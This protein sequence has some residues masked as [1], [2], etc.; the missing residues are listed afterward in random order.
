[1]QKELALVYMVAGIS[2]RFLG[3][4]KQLAVVGAKGE[5]LIECSLNQALPAGFSKIVFIVGNRTEKPFKEKFGNSYKGIP[6]YYALQYYDE[7]ARDKPWGTTD[8]LC[9]AKSVLNCPFIVCNGDDLYGENTFRILTEHLNK[10]GDSAAVGFDLK[11]VLPEEGKVNRGIFREENEHIVDLKEIIGI[12]KS[13]IGIKYPVNSLCSM[14]IFALQPSV[15]DELGI[16]LE[17]FKK[18]NKGDRRKE[19]LLPE[20]IS[21][22][23]KQKKLS[24]RL[25]ATPDEW[26]G[27][28]NP[29]DDEI[30]KEKLARKY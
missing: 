16:I 28:T 29:G 27:V 24:M 17:K 23:I 1:M 4:I 11:S 25:Y 30:I 13:D 15:L 9:S 5:T 10:H 18:E 12:E 3:K 22:L 21:D 20:H 14:N 19:A 7:S 2:S 6:V 26:L 8:A